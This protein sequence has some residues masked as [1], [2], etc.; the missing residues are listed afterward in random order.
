M[1][2]FPA[3]V[4]YLLSDFGRGSYAGESVRLAPQSYG[5]SRSRLFWNLSKAFSWVGST[6]RAMVEP[7]PGWRGLGLRFRRPLRLGFN[8][9]AD[10]LIPTFVSIQRNTTRSLG[11]YGPRAGDVYGEGVLEF[12]VRRE[13]CGSN[14]I[15]T[16]WRSSQDLFAEELNLRASCISGKVST[17]KSWIRDVVDSFP[18]DGPYTCSATSDGVPRDAPGESVYDL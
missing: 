8:A 3:D 17:A 7:F 11:I 12:G 1:D 6:R 13:I 14:C 10:S 9:L 5:A 18:A 16:C 15:G 4:T 2:S